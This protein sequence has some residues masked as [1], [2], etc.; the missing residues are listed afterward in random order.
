M[1]MFPFFQKSSFYFCCR[2][3]IFSFLIREMSLCRQRRC[4]WLLNFQVELLKTQPPKD[5]T[6]V[7]GDRDWRSGINPHR[8]CS[9]PIPG[10]VGRPTV[11]DPTVQVCFPSLLLFMVRYWDQEVCWIVD[12]IRQ[13]C[14]LVWLTNWHTF[15]TLMCLWPLNY[16]PIH[17]NDNYQQWVSTIFAHLLVLYQCGFSNIWN[18]QYTRFEQLNCSPLPYC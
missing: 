12:F 9:L 14:V 6:W 1:T 3:C 4:A 5:V 11:H 8:T 16:L 18:L 2:L 13:F 17:V 10:A 15:S 7:T